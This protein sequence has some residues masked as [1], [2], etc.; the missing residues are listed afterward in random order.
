MIVNNRLS[1]PDPLSVHGNTILTPKYHILVKKDEVLVR[2]P[3]TGK[4]FR[5]HGDPHFWTSDGDRAQFHRNNLTIDLPD[6]TKITI[7]PTRPDRKGISKIATLQVLNGDNVTTVTNI[8]GKGGPRFGGID[9]D[10]RTMDRV[11]RD[12]TVLRVGRE[13][14]DLHFS[15]GRELIGRDPSQR[16][17]EHMLDGVGGTSRTML[18]NRRGR[19]SGGN[20]VGEGAYAEMLDTV[21]VLYAKLRHK[22][23]ELNSVDPEDSGK[24]H[25]ILTGIQMIQ[26]RLQQVMQ[27]LT[28]IMKS[29]HD[30][31][32]AVARNL[33]S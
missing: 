8:S 16:W 22:M 25:R 24:M 20:G 14:D 21:D 3:R 18:Y 13:L 2:D 11:F 6:G 10:A 4:S 33:R 1:G 17:G 29:E 28:N 31:I 26:M 12:G 32:Q 27:T 19:M 15:N 5:A 9:H 30:T 23:G 7:V